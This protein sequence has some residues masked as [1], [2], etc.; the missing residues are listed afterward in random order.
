M[1]QSIDCGLK[2]ESVWGLSSEE[3]YSVAM[4]TG[5]LQ[6]INSKVFVTGLFS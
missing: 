1:L 6:Q 2:C 5:M 3:S 4:L